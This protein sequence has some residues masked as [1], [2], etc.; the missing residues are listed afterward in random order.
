MENPVFSTDAL[1]QAFALIAIF[2]HVV[3]LIAVFLLRQGFRPVALL[4][5]IVG[6]AVIAFLA[7]RLFRLGFPFDGLPF[8]IF[9]SELIVFGASYF[10]LSGAA[11]APYATVIAW[12]GFCGN[13]LLSAGLFWLVFFFRMTRL[14]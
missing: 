4:N 13:F 6:A 2:A 5:M 11:R 3:A 8:L 7:P 14:F 1:I 12:I 9:V 10:A